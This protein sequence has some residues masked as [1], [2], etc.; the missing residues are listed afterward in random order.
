ME[1][2]Q[3]Q[4]LEVCEDDKNFDGSFKKIKENSQKFLKNLDKENI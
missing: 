2:T 4:F 1:R 3:V